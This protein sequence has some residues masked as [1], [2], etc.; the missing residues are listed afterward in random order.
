[1][2][3]IRRDQGVVVTAITAVMVHANEIYEIKGQ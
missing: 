1:L 3:S 2:D